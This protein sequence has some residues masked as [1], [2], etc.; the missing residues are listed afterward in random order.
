MMPV[1]QPD[2]VWLPTQIISLDAAERMGERAI[3]PGRFSNGILELPVKTS[4]INQSQVGFTTAYLFITVYQFLKPAGK[5][6]AAAIHSWRRSTT[7]ASLVCV[8]KRQELLC[9]LHLR[10]KYDNR[11]KNYD[12][13]CF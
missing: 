8:D 6:W 3:G 13:L 4:L 2:P 10:R 12:P 1:H 9:D 5:T 7:C 11:K